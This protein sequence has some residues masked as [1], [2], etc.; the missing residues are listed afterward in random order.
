M[1]IFYYKADMYIFRIVS[2]EYVLNKS[3][4]S[5]KETGASE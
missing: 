5:N 4:L 1:D 2:Y 3:S